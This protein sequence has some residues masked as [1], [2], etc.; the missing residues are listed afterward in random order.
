MADKVLGLGSE[1]ERLRAILIR[2]CEVLGID[3]SALISRMEMIGMEEQLR[4]LSHFLLRIRGE[5][6]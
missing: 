3:T 5:L 4:I 2:R 6:L 1:G